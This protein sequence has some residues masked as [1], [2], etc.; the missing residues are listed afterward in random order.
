MVIP[1]QTST[2]NDDSNIHK[3]NQFFSI[4]VS[5]NQNFANESNFYK[6]FLWKLLVNQYEL[7]FF[8]EKDEQAASNSKASKKSSKSSHLSS[9]SNSKKSNAK[10]ANIINDRSV[11]GFCGNYFERK[12]VNDIVKTSNEIKS[13]SFSLTSIAKRLEIKSFLD[14]LKEFGSKL[15]IVDS[16]QQRNKVLCPSY[17]YLEFE[18]LND[19][20]YCVLEE[21]ARLVLIF[22]SN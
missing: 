20:E 17:K 5:S 10:L 9:L 21:I 1:T 19:I 18:Y 14:C 16:Q 12:C 7:D 15:I 3:I 13:K 4:A 22:N 6:N 8:I 2:D 11:R